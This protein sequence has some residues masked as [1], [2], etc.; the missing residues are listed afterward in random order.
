MI[1]NERNVLLWLSSIG[2]VNYIILQELIEYFGSIC[3]IWTSTNEELRRGLN[4]HSIIAERMIKNRSEQYFDDFIDKLD[5]LGIS[6]ITIIDS[7]YPQQLKGI[8]D[9]P[10]VIYLKGTFKIDPPLISI[11]GARRASSY[12]I[13]AAKHFANEL[14]RIGIGIVSGLAL[15]VDTA[16]HKGVLEAKGKTIA[17]LGCGV[18]QCY[19]PSNRSL[20]N[21]IIEAGGAI[22]SEYPPGTPP[23]KHNFPARNRIIS[24]LS[25]GIIVVE[26][27]ESSGA[28]ITVEYGLEQGKEIYAVPGN[29]N[30]FVSKGTNRLIR[31]GAKIL[32]SI[33]DILEDLSHKY[34]I[35]GIDKEENLRDSL[36]AI[37]ANIYSIVRLQPVH[38]DLL[39]LKSGVRINELNSVLSI[40]EIK[41]L[42]SQLPGKIFTVN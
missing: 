16:A 19:P 22:I 17:I 34:N 15:G 32:I 39:A 12:G 36:S 26:A 6:T 33:E 31:D 28:L 3:E 29:I 9:L 40:L 11:V 30:S 10:Y 37:E 18:E 21:G 23:H 25:E 4:K 35:R 24:G 5:S 41:G 27:G 42:I 20:Y 8:Y 38:I 7:D 14:S 2:G 1:I 13:W